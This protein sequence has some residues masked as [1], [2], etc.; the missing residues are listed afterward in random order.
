MTI[1]KLIIGGIAIVLLL[2]AGISAKTILKQVKVKPSAIQTLNAAVEING[3]LSPRSQIEVFAEVSGVLKP[4]SSRFKEGNYFK[5]GQSLIVIDDEEQQ[6]NLL[7]QKSSLLNQITLMMPDLKTDYPANFPKWEAYLNSFDL[8]QPLQALPESASD[9]ERYF[10]SAKNL[11]NLFYSIQSQE[12]R[13]RKYTI[14]APFNGVVAE[15]N[16]TEGTLVRVG[17]KL[18]EFMNAYNY[19]MEAAVSLDDLPFFKVGSQVELS[20]TTIP[21]KWKGTI[22][23]VSD[24]IDPNTQTARVYVSASG[25]GLKEG[26]YLSGTIKGQAIKEV[27]EIPRDLLIEQS[28][29]YVIEDSVM[30]LMSVEPIQYTT[31]SVLVKGVPAGT[32]LVNESVIGAYE[33]LKVAPYQNAG[34]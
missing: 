9:Q 27:T 2:M 11:Y 5:K 3:R 33:G 7:A 18:G 26:M 23:R 28:A 15:S 29:V 17:Q 32:S 8:K 14:P 19:E 4:E 25:S 6:L 13:S 31:S 30:K 22:L 10:V 21:G 12:V 16:I 20:S 24:R 1:R 34:L